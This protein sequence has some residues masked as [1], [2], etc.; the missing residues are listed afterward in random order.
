[1]RTNA[2]PSTLMLALA[3]CAPASLFAAGSLPHAEAAAREVLSLPLSIGLNPADVG[4]VC[5]AV[6][7]FPEGGPR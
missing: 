5:D 1:M 7:S 4:A 6:A 3:L 2:I